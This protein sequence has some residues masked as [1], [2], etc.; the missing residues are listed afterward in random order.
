MLVILNS[1]RFLQTKVD[2]LGLLRPA[3]NAENEAVRHVPGNRFGL[4]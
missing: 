4:D 1:V 3:R 2:L